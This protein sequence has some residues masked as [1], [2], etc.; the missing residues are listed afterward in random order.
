[1]RWSQRAGKS[2]RCFAGCRGR[3]GH[4]TAPRGLPIAFDECTPLGGCGIR[5]RPACTSPSLARLRDARRGFFNSG[6]Q[7]VGADYRLWPRLCEKATTL[8]CDRRSYLFK[9]AVGAHTARPFSFEAE[10]KN[11]IL[12]A[13]RACEFSHSLGPS[14]QLHCRAILAVNGLKQTLTAASE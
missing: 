12:V 6:F 8:D 13:P 10:L 1:M 3:Y 5:A 2:E 11:I 7:R 14:R 4:L 9:T